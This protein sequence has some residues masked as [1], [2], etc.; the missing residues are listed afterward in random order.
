ML[1]TSIDPSGFD[2]WGFPGASLPVGLGGYRVIDRDDESGTLTLLPDESER[3]TFPLRQCVVHLRAER[4]QQLI[5]G[6]TIGAGRVL[7]E[8]EVYGYREFQGPQERFEPVLI[9]VLA[10]GWTAPAFWIDLPIPLADNGQLM[11]WSIVVA[12]PL[13]VL[14]TF[15]DMVPAYDPEVGRLY[16]IDAQPGGNGLADWTYEHIERILPLAY[17]IAL[18]QQRQHGWLYQTAPID[19]D[20]LSILLGISTAPTVTAEAAVPSQPPFQDEDERDAFDILAVSRPEEQAETWD[21][22]PT[23]RPTPAV[24]QSPV[25]GHFKTASDDDD[26]A[27]AEADIAALLAILPEPDDPADEPQPLTP[28]PAK[29]LTPTPPKPSP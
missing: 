28:D 6:H 1:L 22:V 20:W 26:T 5:R 18:D 14:C 9:P 12:L 27:A 2:R 15:T 8:E 10:T 11:G 7:I 16:F 3:L 25:A 24:E 23:Q 4:D 29:A 21:D 19:I 13:Q 17:D